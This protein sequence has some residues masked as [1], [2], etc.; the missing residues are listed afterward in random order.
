[1]ISDKDTNIIYFSELLK[2][3]KR[4]SKA[5]NEIQTILQSFD[6]E[7]PKFLPETKDIWAR[8]YMPI[9]VSEEKFI[10]FRYDPDY[11][12]GTEKNTRN[13]KTYPDIVCNA[14]KLKIVKSDIILDG[15][16]L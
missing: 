1:M 12:Q 2:T 13:I 4:F 16:M 3:D 6:L 14:I 7:E 10:E 8:D 11:L 5:F 15:E 9:Q